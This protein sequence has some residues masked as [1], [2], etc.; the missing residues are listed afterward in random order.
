MTAQYI[1]FCIQREHALKLCS[2][3]AERTRAK[4]D[5]NETVIYHHQSPFQQ[6]LKL[7]PWTNDKYQLLC[8][9]NLHCHIYIYILEVPPVNDTAGTK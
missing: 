2:T 5:S 3:A 4:S 6:F 7:K 9:Q 1:H 8:W